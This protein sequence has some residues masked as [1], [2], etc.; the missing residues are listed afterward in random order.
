MTLE[1]KISLMLIITFI[2]IGIVF[3]ITGYTFSPVLLFLA[4]GIFILFGLMI[5]RLI[6]KPLFFFIRWI[7]HLSLGNFKR[8]H[9]LTLNKYRFSPF[10]ELE[11]KLELL[12]EELKAAEEERKDLEETRKNWTAGVTHDLKT[13]LSYIQGYATML[14]SEH[15]WNEEEIKE[16][17]KIIEDKSLYM[18]QLINDLSI[19]Y[20]FDSLQTPLDIQ[21]TDLI[22]FVKNVLADIRQYPMADDYAIQFNIENER[23]INL[24]VDQTLLKRALENVIMNAIQH[25]PPQTMINVSIGVVDDSTFIKIID[26]GMGMDD[27]TIQQLFNQHYRGTTTDTPSLG[28]GLGMSIAKQ[29]VE[30]QGGKIKATSHRDSGTII[31]I[32]FPF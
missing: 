1:T 32:L 14:R 18:E 9:I 2:I 26:D 7:D 4:F 3:F 22:M 24:S 11:S 20:E 23:K 6:R 21:K 17:A 31:T 12:T 27:K 28:T 30:K 5:D 25:N 16:F 8:P 13:P 19:V 10:S 15:N 29:F